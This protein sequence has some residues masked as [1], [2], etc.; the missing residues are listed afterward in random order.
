MSTTV[1]EE[2]AEVYS[3]RSTLTSS[4]YS[5]LVITTRTNM[6]ENTSHAGLIVTSSDDVSILTQICVCKLYHLL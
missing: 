6:V 2:K 3:T 1:H 4:S 5:S